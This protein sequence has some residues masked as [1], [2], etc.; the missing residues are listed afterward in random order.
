MTTYNRPAALARVLDGLQRQTCYPDEV[1]VADDGSGD[2][3][4][5]CIRRFQETGPFP[6]QH[7]WH[8]DKGF[9]AAAIRNKAIARASGDY[10]ISLDGD[11]IP[12]RHFIADH[13]KLAE[14]GF[15]YQ[16]RQMLVSRARSAEFTIAHADTA[17]KKLK[18]LLSGQIG[19]GHHWPGCR[20]GRPGPRSAWMAS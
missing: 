10:I 16:G 4:R 11:C 14:T 2:E 12:E 3:T 7:V 13:R 5:A 1:I 18:L 15:F 20:F 8:A 19:N 17:W 6:L 9:R